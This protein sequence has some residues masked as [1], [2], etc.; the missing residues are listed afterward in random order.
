[1]KGDR[2][3]LLGEV[4]LGETI[5]E[6]FFRT[7]IHSDS[8]EFLTKLFSKVV[9]LKYLSLDF[10]VINAATCTNGGMRRACSGLF[11]RRGHGA[12]GLGVNINMNAAAALQRRTQE[13][14]RMV[15]T[16]RLPA[17]GG[18]NDR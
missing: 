8:T 10:K 14:R 7:V 11:R 6:T 2:A 15:F 4:Y 16:V 1:M 9:I 18:A 13:Q 12:L 17:P 3:N 5:G